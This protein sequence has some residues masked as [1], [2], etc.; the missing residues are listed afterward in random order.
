MIEVRNPN[1]KLVGTLNNERTVYTSKLRDCI[2]TIT[3]NPDGT[4]QVTHAVITKKTA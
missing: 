2:T 1:K 3:V 4:L